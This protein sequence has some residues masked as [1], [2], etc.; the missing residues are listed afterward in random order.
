M[1][2]DYYHYAMLGVQ[3]DK[4]AKMDADHIDR[5]VY[6]EGKAIFDKEGK[7]VTAKEWLRYIRFLPLDKKFSTHMG[8]RNVTKAFAAKCLRE[9]NIEDKHFNDFLKEH[10]LQWQSY[11][12][13]QVYGSDVIGL[14]IHDNE[15]EDPQDGIE[16][17]ALPDLFKKAKK[18]LE[19]VGITETPKLYSVLHHSY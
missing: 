16:E 1:G 15:G 18:L 2:S 8:L 11:D 7:P 12:F 13:C 19:K 6:H 10:G 3:A 9:N 17:S 5:P 14:V 4:Y